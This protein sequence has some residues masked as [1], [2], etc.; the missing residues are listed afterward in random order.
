MPGP[1]EGVRIIDLTAYIA[2]PLATMMLADQGAEVIKVEPP[3]VGDLMRLLGTN[4]GGMSVYFAANNRSKRSIVLNLREER[5]REI[6]KQLATDADVLVQNFRPGVVERLGID[7]ASLRPQNSELIYVSISGFGPTGPYSGKGVFDHIIQGISGMA[8]AQ[9]DP[10]TG[11]PEYVRQA[12]CDKVTAYTAAQAITAA[13]LA[14]ERGHGG[15]HVQLAMLD[16]ALAFLSPDAMAN[17]M[18]LEDDVAMQ[19]PIAHAYRV[20]ETRDGHLSV[21]AV[22]D[23]QAHGAFRALGRADLI[24]DPRFATVAARM[25]NLD[26]LVDELTR[27]GTDLDI[28]SAEVLEKLEAEDVPCGPVLAMED[29]PNDPQVQANGVLVETHHPQLGRIRQARPPARFEATPAEIQRPAPGLGDHTDEVLTALGLD[30]A[31]IQDLRGK[32]I[33]G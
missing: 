18:V 13:L 30:P 2:G 12:I 25:E 5:G 6:L 27:S 9:A 23:A 21:A 1:L 28:G 24:D 32:G 8:Y 26:A 31:E 3:G 22:T 29:V 20:T 19:P 15:Q 7:E 10:A 14:R 4:R 11:R 17:Q 16:A 33:V